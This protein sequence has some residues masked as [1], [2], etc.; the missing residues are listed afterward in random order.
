MAILKVK[1]QVREDMRSQVGNKK[2]HDEQAVE[3]VLTYILQEDKVQDG[4]VG[5]FAVN[6]AFAAD[7]FETIAE[8]YGKNYGVWLRHMILSFSP[9]EKID[10]YDAKNIA[11]QVASYYGND[12]QIVWA[13]HTDSRCLNIH[14]VM[15]TV[16][17]QTGMKYDGSKA[18]YYGFEKHI[19][20][21]LEPYETYVEMKSDKTDR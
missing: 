3:D 19:N 4:Y 20:G 17:Y 16:S 8:V 18:D 5:G 10:A 14:M 7:Q 1:T 15:N 2:Y 12:Y 13:C 9:K 11:Y 6:P 21:V